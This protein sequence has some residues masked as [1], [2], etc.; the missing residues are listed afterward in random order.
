M[1]FYSYDTQEREGEEESSK[2]DMRVKRTIANNI[3]SDECRLFVRRYEFCAKP[4]DTECRRRKTK[5]QYKGVMRL[6]KEG[7]GGGEKKGKSNATA[8]RIPWH[9]FREA[10]KSEEKHTERAHNESVS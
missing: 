3:I 6:T 7:K 1:R 10:K 5:R 8:A 2:E 4:K 9:G